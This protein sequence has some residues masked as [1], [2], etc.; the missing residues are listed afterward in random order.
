MKS[1]YYV[2]INR[3]KVDDFYQY[4]FQTPSKIKFFI[5]HFFSTS[6]VFLCNVSIT[7]LY[8][9]LFGIHVD[10]NTKISDTMRLYD[11]LELSYYCFIEYQ[12]TVMP[13]MLIQNAKYNIFL[14]KAEQI[15]FNL[16]KKVSTKPPI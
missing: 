2:A 10:T 16:V 1:Y 11:L 7:G 9:W 6:D 3:R 4:Q 15:L 5:K 14:V 8:H 12:F 13:I